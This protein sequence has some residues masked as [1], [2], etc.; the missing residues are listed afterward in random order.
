MDSA[1]VIIMA[2]LEL[3]KVINELYEARHK[4]FDI[5]LQLQLD[6]SELKSIEDKYRS[7]PGDCFRQ[8]LIAWKTS[9]SQAHKTWSTLA[10][11]LR[12][13]AIRYE[14]LATKV[15]E[16]YCQP[17][18]A[19][20]GE[21]RPQATTEPEEAI[22]GKQQCLEESNICRLENL[23]QEKEQYI[24]QQELEHQ[25]KLKWFEMLIKDKDALI[26]DL[27]EENEK[28]RNG[29]IMLKQQNCQLEIKEKQAAGKLSSLSEQLQEKT[30]QVQKLQREI[31]KKEMEVQELKIQIS[32]IQ[33]TNSSS[34]PTSTKERYDV[35]V[36]SCDIPE[37]RRVLHPARDEW[38]D[39][40]SELDIPFY[41]LDEI[42]KKNDDPKVCLLQTLRE[43]FKFGK[44]S[45]TWGKIAD[46]LRSPVVGHE[47][48]AN[49]IEATY[50]VK[51]D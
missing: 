28:L 51:E 30:T 2:E 47:E 35:D 46:A 20:I 25:K 23:L 49:K 7:D 16:K 27:Q 37:I 17:Q 15:E 31:N 13:P 36:W 19:I 32:K 6:H 5:G 8:M 1:D 24:S 44:K 12:Q 21:K 45:C 40:G 18:R 48:L 33:L 38:Y 10:N 39:F 9:S 42:K 3:P 4:W 50:C 34:I 14:E 22:N 43:W 26:Q 11:I 29:T 41:T